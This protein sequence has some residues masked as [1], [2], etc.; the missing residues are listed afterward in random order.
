M[1]LTEL[2]P[3]LYQRIKIR[4]YFVE[5]FQTIYSEHYINLRTISNDGERGFLPTFGP[6]FVYFYSQ[7][8]TN[9]GYVGK[10]LIE[11]NTELHSDVKFE[12]YTKVEPISS[13]KE[14]I[15]YFLII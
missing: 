10:I 2:F 3:P 7:G 14:V 11:F 8:S 13:L 15:I 12:K 6:A 1:I 4:L 9:E 5:T